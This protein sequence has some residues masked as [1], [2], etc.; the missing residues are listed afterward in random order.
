MGERLPGLWMSHGRVPW[1][2]ACQVATIF[3]YF[4]FPL[5]GRII[6]ASAPCGCIHSACPGQRQRSFTKPSFFRET[7]GCWSRG[8]GAVSRSE[9]CRSMEG[10]SAGSFWDLQDASPNRVPSIT[11][12]CSC[13]ARELNWPTGWLSFKPTDCTNARERNSD[14]TGSGWSCVVYRMGN[15]WKMA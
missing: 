5:W 6:T 14:L 7:G 4:Y 13:Y 8:G 9:V 11:A 1:S 10:T 12:K 2:P 15:K 3:G